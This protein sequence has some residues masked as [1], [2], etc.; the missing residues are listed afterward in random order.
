MSSLP[1]V[2]DS[3]QEIVND[4]QSLQQMEQ[5]MFSQLENNPNMNSQQKKKFLEK[6]KKFLICE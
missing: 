1:D 2:S 5:Q 3:N 6:L 4:I